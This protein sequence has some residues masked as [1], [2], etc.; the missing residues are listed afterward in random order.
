MS[1]IFNCCLLCF[2]SFNNFLSRSKFLSSSMGPVH[3][4]I[5]LH[6]FLQILNHVTEVKYQECKQHS[7]LQFSKLV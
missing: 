4:S 1:S 2:L 7:W 3:F 6:S 5:A